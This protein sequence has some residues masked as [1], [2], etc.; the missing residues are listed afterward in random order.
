MYDTRTMKSLPPISCGIGPSFLKFMPDQ[1]IAACSQAGAIHFCNIAPAK[2]FLDEF[3]NLNISGYVALFEISTSG[4]ILAV[5][6]AFGSI[7]LYSKE[8]CVLNHYSKRLEYGTATPKSNSNQMSI[9][10]SLS[11]IGMPFYN[12][13]LLSVW[14]P[15]LAFEIGRHP[16]LIPPQILKQVKMV[17]FVGYAPNPK[18]FKRNQIVSTSHEDSDEQPKFRSEHKS[19]MNQEEAFE[20]TN[21][22]TIEEG[23]PNYYLPVQIQYSKFGVEDF[24]FGWYNKTRYGGL[25]SHIRNSYLNSL[26]QMLFFVWPLRE[27]TKTH[28]RYMCNKEPCLSCELGFLFRMLESSQGVNCQATNFLRAFSLLPQANALGLLEPEHGDLAFSCGTLIQVSCRFILEQV[29]QEMSDPLVSKFLGLKI[30]SLSCCDH[31]HKSER[32]STPFVVD[33]KYLPK[34][35]KSSHRGF[36]EIFQHSINRETHSKTWCQECE[37]YQMTTQKKVLTELPSF[38]CVNANVN[39]SSELDLWISSDWLPLRIG[40][41]LQGENLRVLDMDKEED[42]SQ[43]AAS[44]AV[45][46]LRASIAEIKIDNK[47]THMVGHINGNHIIYISFAELRGRATMASF[48]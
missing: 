23:I 19:K 27:L 30:I 7:Q 48:Q 25:E 34:E 5:A 41:A 22:V 46:D 29:Q 21:S 6:D 18:T 17:D 8:N 47:P 37:A 13:P 2:H 42:I 1:R 31:Q 12:T 33:L 16:L 20:L 44:I 14:P 38:I 43:Y 36:A 10:S 40:L 26:L 28:I 11:T 39:S 45:Y 24:D 3:L 4:N 9:D 32:E 35:S 15:D